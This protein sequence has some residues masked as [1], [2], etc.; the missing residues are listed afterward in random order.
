MSLKAVNQSMRRLLIEMIL[1]MKK[2]LD[3]SQS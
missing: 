1:F 3:S 2:A